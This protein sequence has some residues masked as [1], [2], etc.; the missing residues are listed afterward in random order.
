MSGCRLSRNAETE[1][2]EVARRLCQGATLVV[3]AVVHPHF[4]AATQEAEEADHHHFLEDTR[5]RRPCREFVCTDPHGLCMRL[6][7]SAGAAGGSVSC[8]L[9]LAIPLCPPLPCTHFRAS[10]PLPPP[11]KPSQAP[12]IQ[13]LSLDSG[14]NL[15]FK[16]PPP[17]PSVRYPLPQS[18]RLV[19]SCGRA[20]AGASLQPQVAMRLLLQVLVRCQRVSAT[21]GGPRA[22]SL[23]AEPCVSLMC[24][25]VCA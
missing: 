9:T 10:R 25:V 7:M 4:L 18:L 23:T 13:N 1:N 11:P 22:T 14:S 15:G 24:A 21:L 20:R 8:E 19:E 3:V 6:C 12:P 5:G 16:P 17:D 2:H